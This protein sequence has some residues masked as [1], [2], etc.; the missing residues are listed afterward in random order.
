MVDKININW[1]KIAWLY[2]LCERI[3]SCYYGNANVF[4]I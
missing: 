3:G 1:L 4:T 2:V